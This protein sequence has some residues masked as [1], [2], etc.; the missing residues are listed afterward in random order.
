MSYAHVPN[1]Y[2]VESYMLTVS[3]SSPYNERTPS[4]Y[5]HT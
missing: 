4:F 3:L 2:T 1:I 5:Y